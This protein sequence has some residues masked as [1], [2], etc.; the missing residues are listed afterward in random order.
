MVT[1]LYPGKEFRITHQE[2]IKGMKKGTSGVN[3]R[4]VEENKN[5]HPHFLTFLKGGCKRQ[6]M[7]F[8]LQQNMATLT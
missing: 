8:E 6:Y 5:H 7:Y 1:L 3:Y 2:M 4:W